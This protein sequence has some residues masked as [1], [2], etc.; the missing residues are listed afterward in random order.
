MARII[1]SKRGLNDFYEHLLFIEK[2]SLQNAKQ[3]AKIIMGKIDMLE[4]FPEMGRIVPEFA[5]K[6]LRE[7]IVYQYRIVYRIKGIDT[8]EV[9][10]I[11][12]SKQLLS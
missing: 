12:H 1:W 10:S 6:E 9:V 11:Y 3:V 4:N 8:V 2:T 5:Q 7:L